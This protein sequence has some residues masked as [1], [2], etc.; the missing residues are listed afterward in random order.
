MKKLSKKIIALFLS[1]VI[2]T[3]II[4]ISGINLEADAATGDDVVAYARTF[5]GYPYVSGAKGPSSFDCSGFVYY[6]FNHFGIYIPNSTYDLWNYPSK[7]GTIVGNGS[8]ANAQ[9]GDLIIW[10]NHVSIY[11]SDGHC[12][13]ALN[14]RTGVTEYLPVNSHTN[15]MNYYVLRVK[16]LEDAKPVV[17]SAPVISADKTTAGKGE[18]I[19]IS[20]QAVSGA[21]TYRVL[22]KSG[23]LTYVNSETTATSK[24]IGLPV[25]GTYTVSV[26]AKNEAGETQSNEITL[27]IKSSSSVH[28]HKYTS[29]ITT[30]ATCET[31]GVKTFTCSC[32]DSYTEPVPATGHAYGEWITTK[33]ATVSSAG[34]KQRTCKNCGKKETQSIPKLTSDALIIDK[35]AVTLNHNES[36]QLMANKTVTWVSSNPKVAT[37]DANGKV[38]A[39][40]TGTAVITAVAGSDTATC[41]VTVASAA[42]W[43]TAIDFIM[44]GIQLIMSFIGKFLQ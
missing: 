8:T 44:N 41:N 4:P 35:L 40:G 2:A 30:A 22:C 18:T 28:T 23:I 15:G 29:K 3:A 20:W 17:P 32:G 10:Y 26:F 25:S 36:A 38:T 7:Y 27:T 34:E 37:V 24:T 12:V 33:L 6:V 39:V 21:E 43:Q 11:T 19:T 31:S 5:I 42:W 16:G 14:S 13:E 9:A 1:L